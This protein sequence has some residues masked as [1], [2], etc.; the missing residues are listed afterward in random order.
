LW[1]EERLVDWHLDLSKS[2]LSNEKIKDSIGALFNRRGD[3]IVRI[4]SVSGATVEDFS[5]L[6]VPQA[7]N[8]SEQLVVHFCEVQPEK[9]AKRERSGYSSDSSDDYEIEHHEEKKRKVHRCLK[10]Q[11]AFE[12]PDSNCVHHSGTFSLLMLDSKPEVPVNDATEID[13][14]YQT[15]QHSRTEAVREWT[16]CGQRNRL[17]PGCVT[18]THLMDPNEDSSLDQKL[19]S[20]FSSNSA[21]EPP[22]IKAK[23]A[24]ATR[25][26]NANHQGADGEED[27]DVQIIPR[28]AILGNPNP[29][30]TVSLNPIVEKKKSFCL[31][32]S[33]DHPLESIFWNPGVGVTYLE[34]DCD[35]ELLITV[36]FNTNVK[37]HLIRISAINILQAPAHIKIFTNKSGRIDFENV[38]ATKCDQEFE[39]QESSYHDNVAFLQLQASK[40]TLVESLTIY[41]SRNLGDCPTTVISRINLVGKAPNVR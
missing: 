13:P 41:V 31:N 22:A 21:L 27:D 15:G 28:A 3:E 26:A 12:K 5:D 25:P 38:G 16:C 29:Q 33:V 14:N 2:D 8:A 9:R 35:A 17:S 1:S 32:E 18:G 10:C 11:G 20:F 34:S 36:G 40:F 24:A 6:Y 37:L 4:T 30:G 39:L 23:L 7:G 19:V